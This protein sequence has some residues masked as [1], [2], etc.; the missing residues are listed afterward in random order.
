MQFQPSSFEPCFLSTQNFHSWWTKYYSQRPISIMTYLESLIKY[1]GFV[2]DT[3]IRSKGKHELFVEITRFEN[4][5]HICYHP[6]HFIATF[7]EVVFA[8]R[9]KIKKNKA[10][11]RVI[12]SKKWP[13]RVT[14]FWEN[15]PTIWD[16][17][18]LKRALKPSVF[19]LKA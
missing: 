5:Y 7:W 9:E 4:F 8:L 14:L 18:R 6:S 19:T 15:A 10:H 2:Q 17:H 16:Q 13:V 12:N 11:G 3:S 1:H